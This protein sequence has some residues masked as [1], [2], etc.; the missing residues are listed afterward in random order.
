[1]FF[2]GKK[3][4]Q[5][6]KNRAAQELCDAI[7]DD[8]IAASTSNMS[9][10]N[11]ANGGNDVDLIVDDSDED[12]IFDDDEEDE[13]ANDSGNAPSSSLDY[14]D[15]LAA[16]AGV[17]KKVISGAS[18][19]ESRAENSYEQSEDSEPEE[20]EED[21]TASDDEDKEK[22]AGGSESGE[23]YTDDEDEG[24][25]GYRPG[26]YH[27]V[28]IG[29]VYNQRYAHCVFFGIDDGVHDSFEA[30]CLISLSLCRYVVIKKLGWGHFSTVWMVKDRKAAASSNREQFL[31]MKVQKSA[32]HYTEAAMDEVELLDCIHRERKKSSQLLETGAGKDN[33]GVT[34]DDIVEFSQYVAT[35]HD[36]FFH[37]GPNG[38]HMCMVF[39][40]LGNNLLAVIKAFNY[41]GIPIPVVKN[42]IRG[43]CKGLDFLHRKCQIIHTDLKPENVLLYFDGGTDD[44]MSQSMA[45]LSLGE[46]DNP[47]RTIEEL[48]TRL[49]QDHLTAEERKK[50][51]RK[52]KKKRQKERRKVADGEIDDDDDEDYGDDDEDDDEDGIDPCSSFLSDVNMSQILT[53][54]SGILASRS[55][56][57]DVLPQTKKRLNHSSF[58]TANFGYRQEIADGKLIQFLRSSVSVN[59]A[60]AAEITNDLNFAEKHGGVAEVSFILRA[61]TPEEE[62]ADGV[63]SALGGV[64]WEISKDKATREW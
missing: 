21:D 13:I 40:M 32:E 24:E 6:Q 25:D 12:E 31:A 48:E 22:S 8:K 47:I 19:E 51:K 39:S 5:K 17:V 29:E 36:S 45:K 44:A 28:K 9:T 49:A 50:L 63:S 20:E 55:T 2:G 10:S 61:F 23:D 7:S 26:G 59:E 15:M 14:R 33:D 30:N 58:V 3:K 52:L 54:A 57:S 34:A 43:I 62:L 42:M 60:S 16:G 35:L 1:M 11:K 27:P 38:R 41:R 46:N 53:S 64:A 4:K 56:E 18:N 37:T